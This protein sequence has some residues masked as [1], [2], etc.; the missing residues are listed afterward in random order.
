[1]HRFNLKITAGLLAIGIVLAA[2]GLATAATPVKNLWATV[3]ICD[4]HKHPNTIGVR[5]RMPGNGDSSQNMFL[6]AVLQQ[7]KSGKWVYLKNGSSPW[8]KAGNAKFSWGENGWNFVF[9]L[10]KGQSLK[11]RGQVKYQWRK[12]G[13]VVRSGA[14]FT[15]SGHPSSHSDP[16]GYSAADCTLKG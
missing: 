10:T 13:K 8:L 12:N 15:T 9:K 6:K 5:G 16:E 14:R 7:R 1:M 3:N 4:T 2:S 11:L